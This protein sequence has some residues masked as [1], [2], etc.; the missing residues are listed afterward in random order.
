VSIRN[1]LKKSSELDACYDVQKTSVQNT[2]Q[3][4][5]KI[6]VVNAFAN[7]LCIEKKSK[8]AHDFFTCL[9]CDLSPFSDGQETNV[10]AFQKWKHGRESRFLSEKSACYASLTTR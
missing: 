8:V 3:H 5:K 9:A 7:D 2:L 4:L 1:N 6:I 10:G